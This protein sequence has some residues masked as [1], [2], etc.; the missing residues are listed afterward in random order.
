MRAGLRARAWEGRKRAEDALTVRLRDDEEDKGEKRAFS[1]LWRMYVACCCLT[2]TERVPTHTPGDSSF[3]VLLR[4]RFGAAGVGAGAGAAA[5][6]EEDEA[7]VL[8]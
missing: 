4:G 3:T 6:E 1:A 5:E 7:V 8:G 2:G